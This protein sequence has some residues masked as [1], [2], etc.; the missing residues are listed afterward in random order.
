M[1]G[2]D[3]KTRSYDV[4]RNLLVSFNAGDVDGAKE[5]MIELLAIAEELNEADRKDI[6][7]FLMAVDKLM[8]E[9]NFVG[10]A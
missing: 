7:I 5:D 8:R 1:Q 10:R 6:G 4:R 3:A 2:A 9:T